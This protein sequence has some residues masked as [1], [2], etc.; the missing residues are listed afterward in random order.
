MVIDSGRAWDFEP[1]TI[2]RWNPWNLN[3]IGWNIFRYG[4]G[5]MGWNAASN[6]VQPILPIEK[7]SA[8]SKFY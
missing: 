8:F 5:P 7:A 1:F 4:I 6:G 3:V 2:T